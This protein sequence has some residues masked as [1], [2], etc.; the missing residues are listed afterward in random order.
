ML[1][2]LEGV[3]HVVGN[4]IVARLG[5]VIEVDVLDSEV[6]EVDGIVDGQSHDGRVR[7]GED[8]RDTTVEGLDLSVTYYEVDSWIITVKA[9]PKALPCSCMVLI[10]LLR[11]AEVPSENWRPGCL[12]SVGMMATVVLLFVYSNES[13]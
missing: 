6:N 13:N 3:D 2:A 11:W 10:C 8:G 9:G 7:V 4:G 1:I 12:W 5:L